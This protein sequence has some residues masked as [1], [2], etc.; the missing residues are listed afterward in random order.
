MSVFHES[1]PSNEIRGL[2]II[3][4]GSGGTLLSNSAL[5]RLQVPEAFSESVRTFLNSIN[6]PCTTNDRL[7][8]SGVC[9][10]SSRT[11]DDVLWMLGNCV[12]IDTLP[13]ASSEVATADEIRGYRPFKH[14]YKKFPSHPR[15][16]E[17][18]LLVGRDNLWA[19][20]Y[21]AQIHFPSEGKTMAVKTRLG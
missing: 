18:I 4:N 7:R 14:L 13:D 12:S 9:V 10:R 20:K 8:L 1:E 5:R 17:T 21:L 3:D 6:G 11:R 16:A 19:M 15:S 2:A